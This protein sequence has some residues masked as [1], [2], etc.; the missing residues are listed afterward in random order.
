M[1]IVAIS[2]FDFRG[3]GYLNIITS[4]CDGLAKQGH[5]IKA[6]GIGYKGEEHFWDFS[7][8]PARNMQE[9]LAIT[10]N[11]YNL[12]KFDVLI[13]ALDIYIQEQIL[14]SMETKPFKYFGIF[15]VESA[16]L[17]I[18]WASVLSQM[19]KQFVISHFGQE[20]VIKQ[21]MLNAVYLPVGIDTTQWRSPNE[22]ERKKIRENLSVQD[23]EFVILTVA[24]NQERKNLA[25]ALE[26][27]AQFNKVH[28]NSRYFLVTRKYNMVGWRLDDMLLDLGIVGKVSIF[29]RGL[30][31]DE[32]WNLYAMADCF[33]LT[34]KAEGL[35]VPLLEALAVGLPCIGTDCT[36]MKELLSDGRGLL[37]DYEYTHIDPFGN[38]LR[39]WIDKGDL[40]GVLDIIY[41]G[42]FSPNLESIQTILEEHTWKNCIDILEK[43]LEEIE[44]VKEAQERTAKLQ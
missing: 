3:S 2:D 21:G 22:E 23:D 1:K 39:Y 20:E 31:F 37:V 7:I 10:Q 12:W 5:D 43:H 36:G 42:K 11:L 17:C 13:V 24:D 29:E 33:M 16:P 4:I 14:R 19:D 15:P 30:K 28:P 38:G 41:T 25:A 9:T 8:I 6:V 32:L 34:S 40:E 27:F 35:S 18:S 44:S 26:T